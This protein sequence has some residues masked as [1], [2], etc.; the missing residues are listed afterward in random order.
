MRTIGTPAVGGHA[1]QRVSNAAK[2]KPAREPGEKV[3]REYRWPLDV[4]ERTISQIADLA[5]WMT[6]NMIYR[7]LESGER[8]LDALIARAY[9]GKNRSERQRA[10]TKSHFD[11]ERREARIRSEKAAY[12]R[13]QKAGH[14]EL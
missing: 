10:V 9:V 13:R 8:R 6:R 1:I 7:R 11:Y 3:E 2:P 12:F 5:P 14:K 4:G